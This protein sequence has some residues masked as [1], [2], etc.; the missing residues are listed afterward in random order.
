M[1][2][3]M[4]ETRTAVIGALIVALGPISMALYTPAM[5]TL[6]TVFQT[7]PANIK[8]TLTVFFFGFAFAQLVCGPLSDA[9]GRRPVAIGFFSIYLL[10]SVVAAASPSIEWLLVGRSLQG[11]GVAAGT[12]I[13]R[14]IVRDQFT[15]Q[16]SARILNLIGMM[17]AVGPALAPILGGTMLSAIGWHSIFVAMVAYGVVVVLLLWLVVP[18]TNATQDPALAQPRGIIR[19][20]GKLLRDR[21]F[22]RASLVLG[23]TLGGLF[24]MSALVPFVLMETVGLTPTQFGFAMVAQTGAF[25]AGS[26]LT[27]R[28]LRRMDALRLVPVGLL[29][30]V[31]AGLGFG[32]GLRVFSPSVLSVMGPAA[33]WAFGIALVMPGTTTSA[34]AGFAAI[35]GAASALTGF[36]QV[37]GG[38]AGSAVAA[39]V[40]RDPFLA[41]TVVMPSM[42]ALAALVHMGL[43]G[44]KPNH[45]DR[46]S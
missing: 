12:A 11:I 13:S 15:G 25:T 26:V 14:A 28:L 24:T 16:S 5:P 20:Y 7:T 33:L 46:S 44:S 21:R 23:L 4:T 39:L 35:A 45:S 19:S 34:M 18:E 30:V 27:A 1:K 40:F 36:L 3:I 32:I 41:L 8:L 29:L 43:A 37:G 10:G 22:M 9:Y 6:V 42:A 2:P 17:L 31:A 38:L